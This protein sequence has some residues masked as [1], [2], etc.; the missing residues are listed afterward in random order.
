VGLAEPLP[1]V[2]AVGQ[3]GC[4]C[5]QSEFSAFLPFLKFHRKLLVVPEFSRIMSS[6]TGSVVQAGFAG[7]LTLTESR[8]AT[9]FPQ[10]WVIDAGAQ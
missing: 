2:L 4:L 6:R 3:C 1:A 7:R 10:R 8:T 9:P 5:C